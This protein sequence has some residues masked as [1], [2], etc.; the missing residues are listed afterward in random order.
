MKVQSR[1]GELLSYTTLAIFLLDPAITDPTKI[2][3]AARALED[4]VETA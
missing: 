3:F 1:L 4:L 2:K